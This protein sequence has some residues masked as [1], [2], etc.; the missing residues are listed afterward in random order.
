MLAIL[1]Q[2]NQAMEEDQ[3]GSEDGSLP[4]QD[5]EEEPEPSQRGLPDEAVPADEPVAQAEVHL[6]GKADG[7]PTEGQD[8][9]LQNAL[10]AE[11]KDKVTTA[12]SGC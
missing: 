5:A 9:G 1:H 11:T 10:A 4:D 7:A 2:Q 12:V 3:E 8:P 6:V